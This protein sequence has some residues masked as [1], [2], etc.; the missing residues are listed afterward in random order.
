MSLLT[1]VSPTENQ[2]TNK[3]QCHPETEYKQILNLRIRKWMNCQI[4]CKFKRFTILGLYLV[5]TA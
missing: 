3:I 4:C 5:T 1:V 2:P